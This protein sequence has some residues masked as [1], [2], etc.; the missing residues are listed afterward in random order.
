MPRLHQIIPVE[1]SVKDTTHKAMEE[2]RRG[3]ANASALNGFSK[4]YRPKDEEGDRL[5]S[6]GKKVQYTAPDILALV[7]ANLARLFNIVATKE[8]ANT[9]AKADVIVDGVALV[10]QAPVTYLLFLEKQVTEM[11]AFVNALPTLD[12]AQNWTQDQTTAGLWKAEPVETVRNTK[13]TEPV[14][15]Y[16][17]TDKH[18]AQVK[19]A[20]RDVLAGYWNLTSFSGALP[21]SQVQEM[22]NRLY[23]LREAVL[24]AREQA[25]SVE[26]VERTPGRAVVEFVFGL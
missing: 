18:P 24:H 17:H 9:E 7:G 20:T 13:V 16:A 14:V 25:N 21:A 10:S 6:E 12:P 23:K 4:T 26:A 19:E 5:P 11:L 3:L 15:L 2:A 8:Y 1:K 22:Q